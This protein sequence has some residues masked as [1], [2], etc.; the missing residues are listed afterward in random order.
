[1]LRKRRALITLVTGEDRL[2]CVFGSLTLLMLMKGH[3]GGGSGSGGFK[4]SGARVKLK[5][6]YMSLHVSM[7]CLCRNGSLK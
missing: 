5:P 7:T 3:V 2:S 6:F 1:L 4:A